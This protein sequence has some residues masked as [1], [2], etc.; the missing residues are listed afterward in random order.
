MQGHCHVNTDQ[1]NIWQFS[2]KKDSFYFSAT[3]SPSI[4]SWLHLEEKAAGKQ[5]FA[6]RRKRRFYRTSWLSVLNQ[7]P[8]TS[9]E[10]SKSG[11]GIW[12]PQD[13]AGSALFAPPNARKLVQQCKELHNFTAGVGQASVLWAI[14]TLTSPKFLLPNTELPHVLDEPYNKIF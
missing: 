14:F 5:I 2:Q 4:E 3:K 6:Y 9:R 8:T 13:R 11:R 1:H 12:G 7:I 10:D